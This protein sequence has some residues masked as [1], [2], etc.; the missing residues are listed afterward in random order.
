MGAGVQTNRIDVGGLQAMW[1]N[2]RLDFGGGS[3][4][5]MLKSIQ[6]WIN[7]AQSRSLMSAAERPNHDH[8]SISGPLF[9]LFHADDAIC[10]WAMENEVKKNPFTAFMSFHRSLRLSSGLGYQLDSRF[11][12]LRDSGVYTTTTNIDV[13]YYSTTIDS[14]PC[15]TTRSVSRMALT[16]RRMVWPH[17]T[18]IAVYIGVNGLTPFQ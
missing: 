16:L 7:I 15:T 9:F 4:H 13:H 1:F 11:A 10:G 3:Y 17:G 5:L 18:H 2:D 8:T 14:R 6:D 12:S